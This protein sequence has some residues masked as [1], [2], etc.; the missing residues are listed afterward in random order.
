MFRGFSQ[1]AEDPA[2]QGG[3]DV[4]WGMFYAG[5]WAS[6]LDFGKASNGSSVANMELDLYAGVTPKFGNI[7]FDFGVI[8][9]LYPDAED[10]GAELDYLELKAGASTTIQQV[11]V[12]LT[13]YY[14]PEYTGSA[15]QTVTVEGSASYGLPKFGRISPSVSALIGSTISTDN[16]ANFK[17]AFGNGD[18]AYIYWNAG[19]ELAIDKITMDFRYWDTDISDSGN[20]CGGSTFQCDERFVVS[21]KIDF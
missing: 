14:S 9:Y 4:T 7:D 13:V 15:G 8:G 3:V 21:A 1:S 19:L 20:F 17:T 5:A 6:M 16:N 10:N 2:L 18:D 11:G 12:G